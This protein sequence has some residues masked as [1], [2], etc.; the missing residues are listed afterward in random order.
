MR[1]RRDDP[2]GYNYYLELTAEEQATGGVEGTA[3]ELALRLVER[4]ARDFGKLLLDHGTAP[5]LTDFWNPRGRLL[6]WFLVP[7]LALGTVAS[8]WR[9]RHRVEDRALQGLFW[10]LSLPLLFT[11]Q[12]HI[13]RLIFVIPLLCI[14][15]A[16]GIVLAGEWLAGLS[17]RVSPRLD[18][19][20]VQTGV[21]VVVMLAAAGFGWRDYRTAPEE[22]HDARVVARLAA[23]AAT[24]RDTGR[25]AVYVRGGGDQ[26]EVESITV[27]G[28]RLD[29]DGRYQ[30]VD[31]SVGE[32][33]T[34][35]DER[36]VLYTGGLLDRIQTPAGIPVQCGAVYYVEPF[37]RD[38]FNEIAGDALPGCTAPPS[39]VPLEE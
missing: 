20:L 39:V 24:L 35:D 5:A 8:L 37:A 21:T 30:F 15:V 9:M 32:T 26:S 36:P 34:F 17:R 14:L 7:F 22:T 3:T 33:P 29:L 38:R 25:D 23:D 1:A 28:Y 18:A 13:G 11:S 31:L 19:R 12:V 6:P 4:N 16:S 27:A 2:A 10:G